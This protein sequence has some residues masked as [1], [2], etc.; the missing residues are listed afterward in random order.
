MSDTDIA[1]TGIVNGASNGSDGKAE[2]EALLFSDAEEK[3]PN[4]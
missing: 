4:K 1:D 2:N 3:S